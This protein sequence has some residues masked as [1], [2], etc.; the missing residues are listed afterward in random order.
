MEGIQVIDETIEMNDSGAA[1]VFAVEFKPQV[2]EIDYSHTRYNIAIPRTLF[3][4][5]YYNRVPLLVP[6]RWLASDPFILCQS[7]HRAEIEPLPLP[8]V[9]SHD[10]GRIC[11]G[12]DWLLGR[13]Y[14]LA[15]ELK[16]DAVRTAL[17]FF[18]SRFTKGVHFDGPMPAEFSKCKYWTQILR[19]W[20]QLTKTLGVEGVAGLDWTRSDGHMRLDDFVS[21]V[22][23]R[24][25]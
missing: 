20:E 9:F 25:L 17:E 5:T 4:A 8:N 24:T 15:E 14:K 7:P 3:L 19:R 10:N 22:A 13:K 21:E 12:E 6:A 1:K 23:W 16:E 18:G 11:M 2:M